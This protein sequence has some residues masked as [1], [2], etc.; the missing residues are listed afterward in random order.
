MLRVALGKPCVVKHD[1]GPGALFHERKLRNGISAGIPSARSPHLD[2][3]FVGTSSICRPV[4]YPPNKA[5]A[6]PASRLIC[7]GAASGG[8][9]DFIAALKWYHFVE[10]FGVR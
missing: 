2:D 6:P 3:S 7:V 1:L 4:T 8:I 5:K 9:P 10:L